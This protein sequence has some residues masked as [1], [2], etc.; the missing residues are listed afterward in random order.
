MAGPASL[1]GAVRGDEGYA[2]P[3]PLRAFRRARSFFAT[4]RP[5][6]AREGYRPRSNRAGFDCWLRTERVGGHSRP[7]RAG[8][9]VREAVQPVAQSVGA[10]PRK[11]TLVHNASRKR[12]AAASGVRSR[13]GMPNISKPTMNL[14]MDAERSRGG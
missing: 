6:N 8:H 10:D 9:D 7:V 13:C 1:K 14:R 3:D 2:A 12:S 5:R 11:T 4:H